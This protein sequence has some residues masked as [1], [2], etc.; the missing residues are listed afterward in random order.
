MASVRA[1]FISTCHTNSLIHSQPHQPVVWW[2]TADCLLVQSK[3]NRLKIT[4]I[5]VNVWQT[6]GTSYSKSSQSNFQHQ[7]LPELLINVYGYC[8]M[9]K[10]VSCCSVQLFSNPV[11][12][13][14]IHW[15]SVLEQSPIQFLWFYIRNY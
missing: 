14:K 12:Y 11:T 13:N 10:S 2:F 1:I 8:V 3:G 15:L 7:Y 6:S 4:Q 5:L 9:V